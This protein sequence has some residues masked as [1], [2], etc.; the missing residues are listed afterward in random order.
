M[1]SM[2]TIIFITYT[3]L[4]SITAGWYIRKYKRKKKKLDLTIN[5]ITE[6]VIS[7]DNKGRYTFLNDAALT[8]HLLGREKTLGKVIWDVFPDTVGTDFWHLYHQALTSGMPAEAENYFAT[9]DKWFSIKIYPSDTGL[10][11]FYHDVTESKRIGIEL[12]K[13]EE[14]YRTLFY[15]SPLPTW[16]YDIDS[17]C[18]ID[19]NEAA[20]Q[21][22]G[23]TR[24]EFLSMTIKDI[25][26]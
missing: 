9:I 5:R 25:R 15:K 12:T 7:V 24:G 4:I 13:S 21:H 16:L 6:A 17:L 8:T 14:K 11:I 19:V 22:Y 1:I 2:A 20:V 23:Y 3:L 18:L 10:T 26:P